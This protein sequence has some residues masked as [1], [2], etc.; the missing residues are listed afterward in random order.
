MNSKNPLAAQMRTL[1]S[2]TGGGT[3][4]IP[5]L[6][7]VYT[8]PRTNS[9]QISVAQF[10]LTTNVNGDL[11][12]VEGH[13]ILGRVDVEEEFSLAVDAD[14]VQDLGS[15]LLSTRGHSAQRRNFLGRVASPKFFSRVVMAFTKVCARF[16]LRGNH[17]GSRKQHSRSFQDPDSSGIMFFFF[18]NR[19]LKNLCQKFYGNRPTFLLQIPPTSSQLI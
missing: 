12:L 8:Q 18:S 5:C 15:I 17:T 16:L 9:P 2:S 4:R 6:L 7:Q 11:H 14:G 3:S 1:P 19:L 10:V 13:I